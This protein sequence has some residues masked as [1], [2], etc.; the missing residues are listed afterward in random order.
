MADH[1]AV[2]TRDEPVLA[3]P[4]AHLTLL[5]HGMSTWNME[6]R[7][8]GWTDVELSERGV[9]EARSAADMLGSRPA[10]GPGRGGAAGD[11]RDARPAGGAAYDLVYTSVLTRA[12]RTAEIV[13]A[14]LGLSW[15]ETRR[16][17]RLNERHYGD[18]QG[19]DKKQTAARFGLEQVTAWR[20]SY[21]VPPPPLSPDD[22]RHPRLDARYAAL[23]LDM[24]PS[25]ECLA[26]VVARMLPYWHDEIYPELRA[27][28]RVLV[29]AHGNSLRALIKHLEGI[30]DDAIPG[31][32]VPTGIPRAYE[33]ER[34]DPCRVLS[35][36][37]LGDPEAAAKA[38][39]AVAAQ[40]G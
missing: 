13:L 38:A 30:S 1:E 18:L 33:L 15:V 5:R 37:Y 11:A 7:F 35:A 14:R 29:V 3:A 2:A 27:G 31:V 8:T 28:R 21:D 22:D 36:G 34:D 26:D 17:W 25:T 24:L 32:E 19:L 4:T 39:R 20:R 9:Q 40:A 6:N 23:P 10:T 16:H 12:V